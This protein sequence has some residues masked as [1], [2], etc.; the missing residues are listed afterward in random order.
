[1]LKLLM[2]CGAV[3]GAGAAGAIVRFLVALACLQIFKTDFPVATL[4]IN[5]TGSMFL[6][7]F[8]TVTQER[9]SLTETTRLAIASGF[10]GAYTTFSTF[11]YE[12]DRLLHRG[13]ELKAWGYLFGSLLLGMIAVR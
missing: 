10:V 4:L 2:Q 9:F 1:M 11:M 7:W 13:Q 12:S 3:G 8:L 6:G 5:I